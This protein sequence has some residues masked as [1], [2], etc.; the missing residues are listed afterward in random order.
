MNCLD[1]ILGQE[2]LVFNT[3][4][5][6]DVNSQQSITPAITPESLD[7]TEKFV[8][9]LFEKAVKDNISDT[10]STSSAPID[11]KLQR[12]L[13]KKAQQ[14][15]KEQA[16]SK[17]KAVYDVVLP[18]VV[19]F[20]GEEILQLRFSQDSV[21]GKTGD[22]KMTLKE[23]ENNIAEKGWKKGS[24]ITVIQMPDDRYVSADNRRLFVAKNVAQ[25]NK[26]FALTANVFQYSD[27]APKAFLQ[28]VENEYRKSH[29][30]NK[31]VEI[32]SQF[33]LPQSIEAQ[34]YGYAM[35]LRINTRQGDLANSH[36]GY[37]QDPVVRGN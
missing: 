11:K 7:V 34:T 19:Q 29:Q 10:Q 13:R 35:V 28:G 36:F 5:L 16:S 3:N 32:I 25:L 26:E 2:V 23:L 12:E 4:K 6:I 30:L 37:E 31:T 24:Q 1:S 22:G 21:D 14:T 20:R 15:R 8:N 33:V 27:K 17:T 9:S 18:K